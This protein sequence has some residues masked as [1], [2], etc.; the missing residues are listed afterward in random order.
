[1]FHR[2]P[3]AGQERQRFAAAILTTRQPEAT[4]GRPRDKSFRTVRP[5]AHCGT[6]TGTGQE[7]DEN[8]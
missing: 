4:T 3:S 6:A 7:E 5:H 1:M 2:K 8:V